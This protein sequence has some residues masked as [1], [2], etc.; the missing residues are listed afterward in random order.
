MGT[1]Q[2]Q[3][4]DISQTSTTSSSSSSTHIQYS[5]RN[6]ETTSK[7]VN[8]GSWLV[9]ENWMTS[10]ADFW[11]GAV[12]A[13]QGEYTAI[14]EATDP[15]TIRSHL[16]Y[17]HSTFINESDIADIAAVGINTVRVPIGYW[18]VGFDDSDPSGKEEWKV[19]TN[20]TIKYLDALITDWAKKYNIA[21]LLS[22]HAAKGS[23]NG[24]DHSSPSVYGSEFWGS[25]SEN[26]NN[27]ITMV[28]YL[29]DRYKDEE[30]FLGFGLLNEPNG[31][32]T[33][34]VLYDYYEQAYTAI[35]AT[36]SECVLTVAPLLY[37]QSP[38]VLTDFML[39][40]S[41][42]NVWVEWHPYFVW[43]YDDVS[44]EDL[45]NT[46]VKVNFQGDM[47]QWNSVAGH[48]RLFIGEWCFATNG[49]FENNED[50]FYE[51]AQAETDVV[52]QAGGVSFNL[53]VAAIDRFILRFPSAHLATRASVCRDNDITGERTR[54]LLTMKRSS[55]QSLDVISKLR[56]V[57]AVTFAQDGR[58]LEIAVSSISANRRLDASS[59]ATTQAT[60]VGASVRKAIKQLRGGTPKFYND[61]I[62]AVKI[63]MC[64][65]DLEK[66]EVRFVSSSD[67]NAY[68]DDDGNCVKLPTSTLSDDDATQAYAQGQ[69]EVKPNCY[70]API[71][72]GDTSRAR[73]YADPDSTM[74]KKGAE[75][76]LK[77]WATGVIGFI[78]PG[79]VLAILSLLTMIFFFICRCCCG[80][81][82]GRSPREEGYTCMQKFLPLLF[83]VLFTIGIVG[84]SA[85]A[86]VYRGTMIGAVGDI[87]NATTGT[88]DNVSVWVVEIRTPLEEIRDKVLSSA[89][90]VT[91]KLKD[92]SFIED[93][94][95]GLE[96]K[97]DTF[98]DNSANRTLPEGCAI[99]T[100]A[101]QDNTAT[102][103]GF[104]AP[105]QACTTISS[106]MDK[107][108][109]QIET[110]AKPGVQQ[111]NTVR[112]QLNEQLVSISQSVR[113]GVNT[114]VG[115]ANDLIK[116]VDDVNGDVG[117]YDTKFEGYR[118]QLGYAVMGL[119]ALALVVVVVGFV[120]ILFGLTPLK[121][122]ANIMHFAYFFGFIA[123]FLTFI[124]SAIVLAVGVV[125]GDVCEVTTIFSANWTVPLGDSAKVVDACFNN[126]SLIDTFNLSSKLEFARGGVQFPDIDIT[127][128]LDFSEL[129]TFS[130]TILATD[131]S[132]FTF[133]DSKY[134]D[135]FTALNK[136][137]AQT[138]TSCNPSPSGPYT[139]ANVEQPWV[140]NS[141][142]APSPEPTPREYIEALYK[143]YDSTCTGA[144]SANGL[145]FTCRKPGATCS[146]S[147]FMGESFEVL[148]DMAG[149]K[150]GMSTFITQLHTNV[151]DVTAYT[152]TFKSNISTLNTAVNN[153]KDDLQS[154]L[155]AY[156][157]DFEDA[158]HCYFLRDGYDQIFEALCGKLMPSLTM[159]ALM[160]FLAGVFLIP[161]NV[162]L[163]IGV[164][165]LKA[166][167]NGHIMDNE[168]KFQ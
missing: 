37:E 49:K 104:C 148:V 114:Q 149:V 65:Q 107:A 30:A 78:I 24:A 74:D 86:F 113:D 90:L 68:K 51:F 85:A 158:M 105:C 26:V 20:G 135:A 161:V 154:S 33:T 110:N 31:D 50:L 52:N 118:D 12:N 18:I 123:L 25:Y 131:E 133:D 162:C 147:Y 84:V 145:K 150:A 120:G 79:V 88:L 23:Q 29:A 1:V 40:P 72:D 96:L 117:D 87:F 81:C 163:I 45:V 44:D 32:T 11:K 17:H 141:Q 138:S 8:L 67:D 54:G 36:G 35:R 143:S 139:K 167:G 55:R 116:M 137:A 69:C 166:H 73:V 42:T 19:Y 58:Q 22:I 91:D 101:S 41:Y 132:T 21:V 39:A 142:P 140:D 47:T 125:L 156:V 94:V 151:T 61:L 13:S 2:A 128:M 59:D 153:I 127:S 34:D 165:R 108:S 15:D 111:L 129:D 46:S 66:N 9:A 60:K 5:I 124:I 95:D 146:F 6:G 103:G 155:I 83:F 27:T 144:T 152:D 164:K 43:G 16:D 63:T 10:S 56:G 106:E 98:S 57:N 112:Q 75:A 160:L 159:I 130:S 109:K 126:E 157:G 119:F 102:D 70:W 100:S 4:S 80:R 76:K 122:L 168:M 92:T 28:S 136:Y 121:A 3:G 82:G 89:D 64:E 71:E 53:Q 38:D 99:D 7:G 14:A 115:T 48:N 93:G 134:D 62:T 97:L 77:E